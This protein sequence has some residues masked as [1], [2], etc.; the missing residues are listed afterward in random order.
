MKEVYRIMF[1]ITPKE[2]PWR[3]SILLLEPDFNSYNDAK[4][5]LMDNCSSP[6]ANADSYFKIELF[7]KVNSL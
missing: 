1:I 2:E 6:Q 3:E 5:Y 7:Y 4:K